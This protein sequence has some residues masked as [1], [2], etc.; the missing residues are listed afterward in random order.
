[1]RP[2]EIVFWTIMVSNRAS[3]GIV[4]LQDLCGSWAI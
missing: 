1:M 4:F 2:Y 3:D